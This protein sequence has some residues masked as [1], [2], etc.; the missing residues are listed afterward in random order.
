MHRQRFLLPALVVLTVARFLLLPQTALSELEQRVLQHAQEGHLW[1]E[2]LGPLLPWLVKVSTFVFGEGGF[3]VRFFAPL[4]ML[5]AGWLLWMLVRGLFDATTASW[6]LLVFQITPVVNLAAV[7]M[8]HTSLGIALSVGVM[9]AVRVALHRDYQFH[10]HWWLLAAAFAV[11]FLADWRMSLISVA[12]VIS[13]LIT[14]RGRRALMKWPVLPVLALALGLMLGWF[15]WW[16]GKHEWTAFEE[17]PVNAPDSWWQKLLVVLI[18]FSPL[19][20]AACGWALVKSAVPRPMTYAVSVL[21]AYAWPL[22]LLD[23]LCWMSFPWPYAGMSAWL[24]PS[25]ALLAH[26]SVNYDAGPMKKVRW[27]RALVIAL[28]AL[29]SLWLMGGGLQRVLGLVW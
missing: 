13:I 5:G 4:L 16:N 15:L 27:V 20:L 19:L 25:I 6:A 7:T 26:V 24:A 3:G 10:L 23:V 29:Q 21:Q 28:A 11:V 22:V 18:A 8:T 17:L 2:G 14:S 12:A 1:Y 9:A